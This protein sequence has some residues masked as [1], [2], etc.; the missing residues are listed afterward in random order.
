M[1]TCVGCTQ[2]SCPVVRLQVPH[3][4]DQNSQLEDIRQIILAI[5]TADFI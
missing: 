1:A 2:A 3:C 5:L 4:P